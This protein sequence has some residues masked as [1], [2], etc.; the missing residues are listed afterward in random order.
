MF[1]RSEILRLA[2]E[3]RQTQRGP[4]SRENHVFLMTCM[5]PENQPIDVAEKAYERYRNAMEGTKL[6]GD[7]VISMYRRNNLGKVSE[8]VTLCRAVWACGER[9][10]QSMRQGSPA[11][12]ATELEKLPEHKERARLLLLVLTEQ[13]EDLL[14][15]E[16]V[17]VLRELSRGSAQELVRSMVDAE[18]SADDDAGEKTQGLQRR[19][20]YVTAELRQLKE[21]MREQVNEAIAEE[22]EQF[23]MM[24]NQEDYGQ[25]LDLLMVVQKGLVKIREQGQVVPM[26]IR[27][28]QTLV[29]CM[30]RFMT[31]YGVTPMAELGEIMELSVHDLDRYTYE[32]TPFQSD[33]QRKKVEVITPGWE[34]S[35]QQVVISYPKV[36]EVTE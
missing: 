10:A 11:N 26:E 25:I 32:G 5:E 35:E 22:R 30:R 27:S 8:R 18:Q 29:R 33:T 9:V 4:Y 20:D 2:K 21:Q 24:L 17:N 31:D 6:T 12:L 15:H 34:L 14:G 13:A 36:R 23:F 1:N 3:L 19:L 16:L 7:R 28:V